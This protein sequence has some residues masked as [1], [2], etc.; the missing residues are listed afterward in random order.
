M[1]GFS[2]AWALTGLEWGSGSGSLL[3]RT[4][5]LASTLRGRSY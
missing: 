5:G 4:A 1:V 2:Y 3:P